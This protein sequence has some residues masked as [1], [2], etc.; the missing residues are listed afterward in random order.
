MDAKTQYTGFESY[1]FAWQEGRLFAYT[2][3]SGYWNY[4]D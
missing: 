1:L 2:F 4:V 3:P